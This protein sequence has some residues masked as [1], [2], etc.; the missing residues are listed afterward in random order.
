[1]PPASYPVRLKRSSRL[2]GCRALPHPRRLRGAS[3]EARSGPP[4]K[5]TA[6]TEI[7]QRCQQ[8]EAVQEKQTQQGAQTELQGMEKLAKFWPWPHSFPRWVL[9]VDGSL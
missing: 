9:E 1:M 3:R 5:A 4:E 2:Q 6:N 8:G 7:A